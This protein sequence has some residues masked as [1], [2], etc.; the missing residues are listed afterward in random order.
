MG[1]ASLGV[2]Y[3]LFMLNSRPV[4]P[5]PGSR[6]ATIGAPMPANRGGGGGAPAAVSRDGR[7]SPLEAVRVRNV[8]FHAPDVVREPGKPARVD[9][10]RASV[11]PEDSALPD[12]MAR[13]L[14]TDG[15]TLDESIPFS[16]RKLRTYAG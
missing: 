2:L 1:A 14:K 10:S 3:I 13:W 16:V 9:W 12:L 11:Y 4:A 5:A 8:P 7:R 15:P 6:P